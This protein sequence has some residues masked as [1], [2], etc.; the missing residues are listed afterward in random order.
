M[1]FR[2]RNPRRIR[3]KRYGLLFILIVVGGVLSLPLDPPGSEASL[4][5]LLPAQ[6]FPLAVELRGMGQEWSALESE[7]IAGILFQFPGIRG[8]ALSRWRRRLRED[9]R[10]W[11]GL[12][13]LS[14]Q[15]ACGVDPGVQGVPGSRRAALVVRLDNASYAAL[16]L[17]DFLVGLPVDALLQSSTSVVRWQGRMV[18]AATDPALAKETV[19]R[20]HRRLPYPDRIRDYP[21][22]GVVVSVRAPGPLMRAYPPLRHPFFAGMERGEWVG[23]R[24]GRVLVLRSRIQLQPDWIEENERRSQERWGLFTPPTATWLERDG[25]GVPRSLASLRGYLHPRL[26]WTGLGQAL[27]P[28]QG[29]PGAARFHPYA[30]QGWQVVERGLIPQLDGRLQ[31]AIGPAQSSEGGALPIPSFRLHLGAADPLRLHRRFDEEATR[32]VDL[33][34]SP[35]G[36]T[37]WEAVRRETRLR[38]TPARLGRGRETRLDLHPL[39]FHHL[40]PAWESLEGRG[41]LALR[42]HQEMTSAASTFPSFRASPRRRRQL[43]D[44][45]ARIRIDAVQLAH[46]R[47]LVVD[48]ADRHGWVAEAGRSE[49]LR[50]VAQAEALL[51]ACSEGTAELSLW[52][53]RQGDK[54]ALTDVFWLDT[55]V[56]F[57]LQDEPQ[58]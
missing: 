12:R 23:H 49:F 52:Q 36:N 43:A 40:T 35:G 47:R 56:G 30:V 26:L 41:L 15:A 1:F 25:L 7:G 42:S 19:A 22:R 28:P 27:Y 55:L 4:L 5:S 54:N 45:Q 48:K 38:V 3:W 34:R 14:G 21:P 18:V 44:L 16:R 24:M 33:F 57:R 46:W 50:R 13:A 32:W 31:L 8:S 9:P 53:R 29:M 39:F 20:L 37:L 17:L 11:L 2:S 6:T 58:K 51:R 10:L